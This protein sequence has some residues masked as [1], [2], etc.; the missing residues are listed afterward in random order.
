MAE[1]RIA[2]V[3]GGNRGIG[4]EIVRQLARDGVMPVM[5]SRDKAKGDAAASK[6]KSEGLEVPVVELDVT[7]QDSIKAAVAKVMK[8]FG[9]LD[10]LVN[11]SGALLDSRD[12][13]TVENLTED[14]LTKSFK[15]NVFGPLWLTQTVLPIMKEQRYGRIVNLS[16][17]LAQLSQ[18]TTGY[19]AGYRMSKTALNALTRLTA[20]DLAGADLDI[21]VNSASPGW[22][23]TETGGP[24]AKGTPEEGAETAVWLAQ[25][26]EDGPTGGFFEKTKMLAW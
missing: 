22:V 14:I 5:G 24:E 12:E 3:S 6:L 1:T 10:I 16:T 8:M 21:K 2:L 23:R 9:R 20:G 26:P 17:E 11:N 18:M 19:Y 13:G 15:T 7:S 4:F 25:L